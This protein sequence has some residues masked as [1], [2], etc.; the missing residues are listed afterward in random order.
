MD[1]YELDS[2]GGKKGW[3]KDYYKVHD[4]LVFGGLL[5]ALREDPSTEPE[6]S[7][8]NLFVKMSTIEIEKVASHCTAAW[9][10]QRHGVTARWSSQ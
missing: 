3:H 4:L 8:T 6:D 10:E 5:K 2:R 9:G 1:I 7:P